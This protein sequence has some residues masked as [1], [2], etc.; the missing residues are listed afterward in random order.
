MPQV[1]KKKRR[2]ATNGASPPVMDLAD[3]AR[4]LKLPARTVERLVTEQGLPG[5]RIGKEWRFLRAAIER[6]LEPAKMQ[7]TSLL[8]QFGALKDDPTY[9][10]YLAQMQANRRRWNAEA[11]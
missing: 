7:G 3:A 4:F 2:P 10:Q 1:T 8:D 5:R 6:W 9:D 11:G